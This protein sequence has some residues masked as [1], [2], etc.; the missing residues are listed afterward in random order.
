MEKILVKRKKVE[1]MEKIL[2]ILENIL[3][4]IP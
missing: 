2:V 3:V 1:K 4:T